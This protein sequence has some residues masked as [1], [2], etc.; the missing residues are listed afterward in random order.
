MYRSALHEVRRTWNWSDRYAGSV[1]FVAVFPQPSNRYHGYLGDT[2]FGELDGGLDLDGFRPIGWNRWWRPDTGDIWGPGTAAV[3]MDGEN[4]SGE[5][6]LWY[7][8]FGVDENGHQ[9]YPGIAWFG[10]I[11]DKPHRI[12]GAKDARKVTDPEEYGA[13]SNMFTRLASEHGFVPEMDAWIAD[14]VYGGRW[15]TAMTWNPN[16]PGTYELTDVVNLM[17]HWRVKYNAS[18][19]VHGF[20]MTLHQYEM[21]GKTYRDRYAVFNSPPGVD[22]S[23]A[24]QDAEFFLRSYDAWRAGDRDNWF[25]DSKTY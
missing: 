13:A 4:Y 14:G 7:A 24:S 12:K 11:M 22:G 21:N 20:H 9:D 16:E 19:R 17:D 1:T 15:Y 25:P 23:H 3:A 6:E 10:G 5:N 2:P 8:H 18:I